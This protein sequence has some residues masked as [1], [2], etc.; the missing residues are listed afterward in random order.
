MLLS[1]IELQYKCN[2]S[3]GN[4]SSIADATFERELKYKCNIG[5][6]SVKGSSTV[7]AATQ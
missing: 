3:S 1:A 2:V 7:A 6:S 4:A 5:S